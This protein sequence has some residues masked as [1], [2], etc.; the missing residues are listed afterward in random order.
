MLFEDQSLKE[1]GVESTNSL[2]NLRIYLFVAIGV[3]CVLINLLIVAALWKKARE[4]IIPLLRKTIKGLFWNNTI[5]TILI[6]YLPWCIAVTGAISLQL[7]S[8]K[9]S[10]SST[11]V[12]TLMMLLL[13]SLPLCFA[14]WLWKHKDELRDNKTLEEKFLELYT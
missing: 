4:K 1:N 11:F 12:N 3:V 5:K 8:S 9:S 14:R 7:K 10:A 2:A 6:S 13:I